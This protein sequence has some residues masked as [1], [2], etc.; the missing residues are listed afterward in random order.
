MGKTTVDQALAAITTYVEGTTGV[1]YTMSMDQTDKDFASFH[2]RKRGDSLSWDLHIQYGAVDV[3]AGDRNAPN[4]FALVMKTIALGVTLR[5]D[6]VTEENL[7][8]FD[9]AVGERYGKGYKASID[10][11][12]GNPYRYLD[13]LTLEDNEGTN[14]SK[15]LTLPSAGNITVTDG[16][17]SRF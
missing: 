12:H 1:R 11:I 14:H 6:P 13:L 10:H 2:Q 7:A 3:S 16:T 17:V 8:Q 5:V 4:P 9:E 15:T